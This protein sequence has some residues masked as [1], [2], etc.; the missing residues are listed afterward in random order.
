M[1]NVGWHLEMAFNDDNGQRWHKYNPKTKL[2]KVPE[3][4]SL[5][6]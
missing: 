1:K 4:F 2:R 6:Q 3:D 5:F